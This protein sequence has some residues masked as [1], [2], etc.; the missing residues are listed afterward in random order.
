MQNEANV[1]LSAFELELVNN[2]DWILTKNEIIEK[3]FRLF[4][5]LSNCYQQQLIDKKIPAE[6]LIQSPKISKGE[7]YKGLPYVM[8]DYPRHF[9]KADVFAIRTFFWWGHFFSITLQLKGYY[10]T[11]FETNITRAISNGE[12]NEAWINTSGEEWIHE[13]NRKHAQPVELTASEMQ[14]HPELIKLTFTVPL[15][16]WNEVTRILEEKF[17]LFSKLSEA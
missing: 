12:L 17:Y 8:L 3:V 16:D 15:S 9:G 2:R 10:K 14:L 11:L 13:L 6:V 5:E 4:G 7:N 1:S